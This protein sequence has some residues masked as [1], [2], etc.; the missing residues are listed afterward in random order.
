M[1]RLAA[2]DD[3]RRG[4]E[5]VVRRREQHLVARLEQRLH[6]HEDQLGDAVAHEHVLGGDA[7][8]AARLRVHDHRLARREDALLVAVALGLRE[9]LDHRQAHGLGR[10]EAERG[11]VADV[12]LDDLV[13]LALELL[14]APR[15]RLRGSRSGRGPGAVPATDAASWS[16]AESCLGYASSDAIAQ[17]PLGNERQKS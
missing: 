11:R 16:R 14:G 15:Q 12:Q 2:G 5:R 7:G 10:P 13:A 1:D 4:P 8:D 3:H 9:V 17:A 6:R